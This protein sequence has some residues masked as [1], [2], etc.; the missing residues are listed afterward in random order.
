MNETTHPDAAGTPE[1][2]WAPF[3]ASASAGFLAVL[4]LVMIYSASALPGTLENGPGEFHFL[5]K[6]FLFLLL[7]TSV[8]LLTARAPFAWIEKLG[9]PA[10]VAALLGLGLVLVPGIGHEVNGARRWIRWGALG[11]QVSDFAKLA[12]VLFIAVH[13]GRDPRVASSFRRGAAPVLGGIALVSGLVVVEP[14]FGTALFL[15]SLGGLLAVVGGLRWRHLV[16]PILLGLPAM[17]FFVWK[18]FDHVQ[19][20]IAVF[21]DPG[22]DPLGKGHQV[23]QS[24]IALGSGGPLGAGLGAGR[25]KLFFLPEDFTDFILALVGEEMGLAGTLLVVGCYLVFFL[26]ALDIARKA[27][28]VT[29]SL[30][31]LGVGTLVSLQGFINVA[32]VTASVPTK[33]ISLP[34]VSYGGSSL[35]V[36]MAALGLLLNVARNPRR[37]ASDA[38]ADPAGAPDSVSPSRAAV[39]AGGGA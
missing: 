27:R 30:V 15:A 28:T 37:P 34:F 33:G 10:L 35:V 39:A 2:S 19:D 24:L 31:A 38:R 5:T 16:P 36:M 21:L 18:K 26:S 20:R 1:T 9:T 7:G 14:D 4:G 13:L 17:A 25:Q 6:Q 11:V 29:G 3:S 32:V 12:L 22:L 23:R 8:L